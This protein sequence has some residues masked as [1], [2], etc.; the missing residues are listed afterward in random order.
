MKDKI[1]FLLGLPVAWLIIAFIS[2][3][4]SAD[5]IYLLAVAPSVWLFFMKDWQTITAA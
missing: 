1:F 4:P 3:L 2:A 5:R